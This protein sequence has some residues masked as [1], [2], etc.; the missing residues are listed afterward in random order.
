MTHIER[1]ELRWLGAP[2]RVTGSKGRSTCV[3]AVYRTPTR[4]GQSSTDRDK[5]LPRVAG[6]AM[7]GRAWQVLIDPVLTSIQAAQV[8]GACV[9]V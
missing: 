2:R 7:A 3:D 9:G 8:K 5:P 4:Q 6:K 1:C